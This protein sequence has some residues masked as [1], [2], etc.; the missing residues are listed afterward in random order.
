MPEYKLPYTKFGELDW[1]KLTVGTGQPEGPTK[2]YPPYKGWRIWSGPSGMGRST[3]QAFFAESVPPRGGLPVRL[4]CGGKQYN[5]GSLLGIQQT[6][7]AYLASF[8]KAGIEPVIH[9]NLPPSA[10]APSPIQS[11][12]LTQASMIDQMQRMGVPAPNYDPVVST[13]P[14]APAPSKLPLIIGVAAAL[15]IV[16]FLWWKF[17]K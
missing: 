6:V 17:R 5:S 14:L 3:Y 11:A 4:T 10:A 13:G 8:P 16:G 12:L 7:D 15:G 9:T 2:E 1:Q